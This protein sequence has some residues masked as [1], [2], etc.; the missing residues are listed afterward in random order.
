MP[1][2]HPVT[3]DRLTLRRLQPNDLERFAACRADPVLARYQG[4]SPL[5]VD[6]ARSF[7]REMQLAPAFETEA[8][9][10]IAIASRP[11]DELIGDIGLCLH[12]GGEAE[13]GFTL[14]RAL[15]GKGLATEALRA[16]IP[17]L[18]AR[19]EVQRVV[20]ITDARNRASIRVLERLGMA[21]VGRT[22]ALFKGE[23]CTE[24][25][26]ALERAR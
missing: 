13:I 20:G 17:A 23:A 5:S 1:E 19:P 24:L 18:F 6:E 15:H 14:A 3:T 11:G 4:W 12:A 2:F 8:W 7:I 25:R 21:L 16:L 10:Q 9:L 22:E 26:Y